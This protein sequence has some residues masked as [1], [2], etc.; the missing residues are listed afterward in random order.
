MLIAALGSFTRDCCSDFVTESTFL[1][2][3]LLVLLVEVDDLAVVNIEHFV[4]PHG[5]IGVHVGVKLK[6]N[7]PPSNR[8]LSSLLAKHTRQVDLG[9]D[10]LLVLRTTHN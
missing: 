2:L 7:E 6:R 3:E 4:G 5:A 9:I 8:E 1:V 10:Y